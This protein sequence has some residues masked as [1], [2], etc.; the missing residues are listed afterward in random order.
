MAMICGAVLLWLAGLATGEH[1]DFHLSEVAPRSALSLLYLIVFGSLVA[2]TAYNWLLD[3]VSPTLIATH[4]YT[5]PVVALLL[6]WWLAGET[7]G[8]RIL[9]SGMLILGAI[10]LV[11]RGTATVPPREAPAGD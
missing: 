3:H 10:L 1:K 7:L 5:N 2:F 4:T 6:G 9:L 11:R 8:G